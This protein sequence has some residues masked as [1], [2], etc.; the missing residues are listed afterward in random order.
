MK[1]KTETYYIVQRTFIFNDKHPHYNSGVRESGWVEDYTC[2]SRKDAISYIKRRE[3]GTIKSLWQEY[4]DH[5]EYRIVKETVKK[6][7]EVKDIIKHERN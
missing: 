4:V 1:T 6:S 5:I 2:Y 3:Q 7:Y